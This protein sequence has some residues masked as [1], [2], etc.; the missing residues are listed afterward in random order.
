LYLTSLPYFFLYSINYVCKA[1]GDIIILTDLINKSEG[2]EG[3]SLKKKK[4]AKSCSI[5]SGDE[6]HLRC[7]KLPTA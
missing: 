4:A 5:S 2:P 6:L 3:G 7:E 1:T